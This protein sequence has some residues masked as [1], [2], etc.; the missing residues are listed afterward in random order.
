MALKKQSEASPSETVPE[1]DNKGIYQWTKYDRDGNQVYF[2]QPEY[3]VSTSK[4]METQP[5]IYV[6]QEVSYAIDQID[7]QPSEDLRALGYQKTDLPPLYRARVIDELP[8]EFDL[9]HVEIRVNTA[10]KSPGPDYLD[11]NYGGPDPMVG[12]GVKRTLE[13]FPAD[14]TLLQYKGSD[15]TWKDIETPEPVIRTEGE[16]TVY[17]LDYEEVL[18]NNADFRKYHTVRINYRYNYKPYTSQ[19]VICIKGRAKVADKNLTNKATVEFIRMNYNPTAAEESENLSDRVGYY[20]VDNEEYLEKAGDESVDEYEKSDLEAKLYAKMLSGEEV[21]IEDT[22]PLRTPLAGLN[23]SYLLKV[24]SKNNGYAYNTDLTVNVPSVAPSYEEGHEGEEVEGFVTAGIYLNLAL[25]KA[26]E[27]QY[28]RDASGAIIY[29][30][31]TGLPVEDTFITIKG[32]RTWEEQKVENG[33]PV[34]DTNGNPVMETKTEPTELKFKREELLAAKPDG[35][36]VF[37]PPS[38]AVY[39]EAHQDCIYIPI[40]NEKLNDNEYQMGTVDSIRLDYSVIYGKDVLEQMGVDQGIEAEKAQDSQ[41]MEIVGTSY[42]LT[43]CVADVSGRVNGWRDKFTNEPAKVDNNVYDINPDTADGKPSETA[44]LIFEMAKPEITGSV[45]WVNW[46]KQLATGQYLYIPINREFYYEVRYGNTAKALMDSGEVMLSYEVNPQN[47]GFILDRLE[48]ELK[49]PDG[50]PVANFDEILLYTTDQIGKDIQENT[51]P[52][53]TAS[54]AVILKG[55]KLSQYLSEDGTKYVIPSDAWKTEDGT[56]RTVCAV[57]V[58][59]RNMKAEMKDQQ[60]DWVSIRSYGYSNVYEQNLEMKDKFYAYSAP[61]PPNGESRITTDATADLSQMFLDTN[62]KTSVSTSYTRPEDSGKYRNNYSQNGTVY[63][64]QNTEPAGGTTGLTNPYYDLY[65]DNIPMQITANYA[66]YHVNGTKNMPLSDMY[67]AVAALTVDARVNP[68]TKEAEGILLQQLAIPKNQDTFENAYD[69]ITEIRFYGFDSDGKA[70][71]DSEKAYVSLSH[72]DLFNSDGTPKQL[73]DGGTTWILKSEKWEALGAFVVTKV[74]VCFDR[75][76]AGLK[77]DDG[78]NLVYQ[79]VTTQ[80]GFMNIRSDFYTDVRRAEKANNIEDWRNW[81]R[82]TDDN[83]WTH[84]TYYYPDHIGGQSSANLPPEYRPTDKGEKAPYIGYNYCNKPILIGYTGAWA[85]ADAYYDS[86]QYGKVS[87]YSQHRKEIYVPFNDYTR[88]FHFYMGSGYG[89]YPLDQSSLHIELPVSWEAKIGEDGQPEGGEMAKGFLFDSLAI[90]KENLEKMLTDD[91]LAYNEEHSDAPR[92]GIDKIE[93]IVVIDCKDS[94]AGASGNDVLYETLPQGTQVVFGRDEIKGFDDGNGNLNLTLE[95]IKR[96]DAGFQ[97]VRYI[98]IYFEKMSQKTASQ[99]VQIDVNGKTNC[100]L[101]RELD[102]NTI[103]LRANSVASTKLRWYFNT[104]ADGRPTIDAGNQAAIFI[105]RPRPYVF[106]QAQFTDDRLIDRGLTVSG[107]NNYSAK[108]TEPNVLTTNTRSMYAPLGYLHGMVSQYDRTQHSYKVIFGNQQKSRFTDTGWIEL[109]ANA[110]SDLVKVE[111]NVAIPNSQAAGK[112]GFQVTS[113]GLDPNILKYGT[114]CAITIYYNGAEIDKPVIGE[115]VDRYDE[116]AIRNLLDAAI[117]SGTEPAI[118]VDLDKKVTAVQISYDQYDGNIPD[119]NQVDPDTFQTDAGTTY[120]ASQEENHQNY[121]VLYGIAD[122]YNEADLST[123]QDEKGSPLT[124]SGSLKMADYDPFDSTKET[125]VSNQNASITPMKPKP[126]VSVVANGGG[127]SSET[128]GASIGQN[129]YYEVTVGNSGYSRMYQAYL[130]AE[131]PVSR[132]PKDE[133]GVATVGGFRLQSVTSDAN[134]IKHITRDYGNGDKRVEL[135][136][137]ILKEFPKTAT[138]SEVDQILIRAKRNEKG[139]ILYGE[140]DQITGLKFPRYE[141]TYQSAGDT[142]ASSS[143]LPAE[144]LFDIQGDTV[145]LNLKLDRWPD[146]GFAES[147]GMSVGYFDSAKEGTALAGGTTGNVYF[148]G[149]PTSYMYGEDG[150]LSKELQLCSTWKESYEPVG[151]SLDVKVISDGPDCAKLRLSPSEPILGMTAVKGNDPELVYDGESAVNGGLGISYEY[152]EGTYYRIM[153]GNNSESAMSKPIL[154][155]RL[156]MNGDDP[157][158]QEQ[159]ERRRGFELTGIYFDSSLLE[160]AG[161]REEALTGVQLVRIYDGI[162]EENGSAKMVE[163]G[164]DALERWEDGY[165]IDYTKYYENGNGI[166]YPSKVEIIFTGFLPNIT[167]AD[168]GEVRLYGNINRY[169]DSV[170]KQGVDSSAN[171]TYGNYYMSPTN[172]NTATKVAVDGNILLADASFIDYISG[173][174]TEIVSNDGKQAWSHAWFDVKEPKPVTR[175]YVKYYNRSGADAA[176]TVVP[177]AREYTTSIGIGNDSISRMENFR[178]EITPDMSQS[179]V[180]GD[181][182]NRGFHTMDMVIRNQLFNEAVI[183]RITFYDVDDPAKT[184]TLKRQ[185]YVEEEIPGPEH[186]F[187]QYTAPVTEGKTQ[188]SEINQGVIYEIYGADNN[189]LGTISRS[190]G[191]V[192]PKSLAD[193]VYTV[194]QGDLLLGRD[195]IIEKAQMRNIGKIV[196][197]GSD[198]LPMRNPDYSLDGDDAK[199]DTSVTPSA[200]EAIMLVGIS[201][202]KDNSTESAN[203]Q[204]NPSLSVRTYIQS[205][206]ATWL[207]SHS[208]ADFQN[209]DKE[210]TGEQDGENNFEDVATEKHQRSNRANSYIYPTN[211]YFDTTI[212]AVFKDDGYIWKDVETLPVPMADTVHSLDKRFS[213]ETIGQNVIRDARTGGQNKYIWLDLTPHCD[214]HSSSGWCTHYDHDDTYPYQHHNVRQYYMDNELLTLGYKAMG[215]YTVDFRQLFYEAAGNGTILQDYNAAAAVEMTIDLPEDNFDAYYVK[216]RAALKPYVT[217][218]TV[219]YSDGAEA[220]ISK[221]EW[222]GNASHHTTYGNKTDYS[223]QEDKD[224]GNEWWRINLVS[225]DDLYGDIPNAYALNAVYDPRD[226]DGDD[227]TYPYYKS[228]AVITEKGGVKQVKI[229]MEINETPAKNGAIISADEGIWYRE[230]TDPRKAPRTE[231]GWNDTSTMTYQNSI[232]NLQEQNKRNIKDQETRHSIEVAGRMIKTGK[233]TASV[234]THLEMGTLFR[235]DGQD[236]ISQKPVKPENQVIKLREETGTEEKRNSSWSYMNYFVYYMCTGSINDYHN[237][238]PVTEIARQYS[239][240]WH[241]GHIYD[242]ASFNVLPSQVTVD[243]GTG[244]TNN[245]KPFGI[246][247][248]NIATDFVGPVAYGSLRAY[249]MGINQVIHWPVTEENKNLVKTEKWYTHWYGTY[250]R[251][252]VDD[253]Y[254]NYYSNLYDEWLNRVAHVD[255]VT[256]TDTLPVISKQDGWYK[257]F[258][259]R[260]LEVDDTI[261]PHIMKIEVEISEHETDEGG[262]DN[263]PNVAYP[264]QEGDVKQEIK[265]SDTSPQNSSPGLR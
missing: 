25:L 232:P 139:E 51:L 104:G 189:L 136:S 178:I 110:Y 243:K 8:A 91:D 242:T 64:Y 223:I 234:S 265:Q 248:G 202:E 200:N 131:V 160:P 155:I 62:P 245:L 100:Y 239:A 154:S 19:D 208:Y 183:D 88:T 150:S 38:Y 101:D 225:K 71:G 119:R 61:M 134:L 123:Q 32:T 262:Q 2:K 44:T 198:F 260:Y 128:A 75:F 261:R 233:N 18:K 193:G 141:V 255:T 216:L 175:H 161:G 133:S 68:D 147:F 3:V 263:S 203:Y 86:D 59:F 39:P 48:V 210:V 98:R 238:R 137:I 69:N 63:Q 215:S 125:M 9:T 254:K 188:P 197:E 230:N 209:P 159:E 4:D 26:G 127:A 102:K 138:T 105:Y 220:V 36:L 28:Q 122:T 77:A 259:S 56:D 87:G 252:H 143:E 34:F 231:S 79:A 258:L 222:T 213:D 214:G 78:F 42:N 108:T 121:L 40:K 23:G 246:A 57:R 114:N 66:N 130:T 166:K 132:S 146:F 10:E 33:K 113:I 191:T 27:P 181:E 173:T 235:T 149:I 115:D 1:E 182:A 148:Q 65:Y 151:T 207:Y 89:Y 129:A 118:S 153:L 24:K 7:Y 145:T 196:V 95:A 144:A 93:K 17:L 47:Q 76:Q 52:E 171:N 41:Y 201:D 117:Q 30:E 135:D 31:D 67:P 124:V 241:A 43:T 58:H 80:P 194:E 199:K 126:T 172:S 140:T 53:R 60:N 217:Q 185:G 218:I 109:S 249:A 5:I 177:Y 228:P 250:G 187:Y 111:F 205:G 226:V 96:K 204:S 107:S 85:D 163:L 176:S 81:C 82:W 244:Q 157:A 45:N 46:E 54:A 221:S 22:E 211:L 212:S 74:E 21:F 190:D 170:T 237:W 97:Q 112:K 256:V 12:L 94:S 70:L 49:K 99:R 55:E 120:P 142:T 116:G 229:R 29:D 253:H 224:A 169:G 184:L 227:S 158:T 240:P 206:F 90:S 192:Q 106:M 13:G 264:T 35:S 92:T 195:Y 164:P 247:A 37:A 20:P 72:D 219:V 257:G 236:T 156:P 11:E 50:E 73:E 16:N 103:G 167:G 186:E 174:E 83:G 15:G 179:T 251:H 6:G 165:R 84:Y 180:A 152:K 14:Y 168:R 162:E